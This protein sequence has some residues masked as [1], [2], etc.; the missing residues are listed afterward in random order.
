MDFSIRRGVGCPGTNAPQVLRDDCVKTVIQL[1]R[2]EGLHQ[3]H[4][5]L[6]VF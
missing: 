6:E 5:A 4:A 3:S 2:G 1:P